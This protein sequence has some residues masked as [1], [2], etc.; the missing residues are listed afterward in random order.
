MMKYADPAA[1]QIELD[2]YWAVKA[3]KDPIALFEQHNHR[4]SL[5]Q[6]KDMDKTPNKNFAEVG[7]GIIDFNE[8][9]E[10]ANLSGMKHFFIE[11]DQCTKPP[12]ESIE[13][14]FRYVKSTLVKHL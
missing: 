8:I 10:K 11:Q 7:S 12:L 3:G 6:V 4:I 1:L 9:F 13:Q 14:S 2:L 5:W